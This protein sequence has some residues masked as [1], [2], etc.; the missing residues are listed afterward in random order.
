LQNSC[1]KVGIEP[2]LIAGALCNLYREC[3]GGLHG[4]SFSLLALLSRPQQLPT[5][6][7]DHDECMSKSDEPLMLKHSVKPLVGEQL[8]MCNSVM[9]VLRDRS[10]LQVLDRAH[11]DFHFLLGLAGKPELLAVCIRD[12]RS[13]DCKTGKV[14][15][16][17]A[18]VL[19]VYRSEGLLDGRH[20]IRLVPGGSPITQSML[21]RDGDLT[22]PFHPL[23]PAI[24]G[25]GDAK[26]V[27]DALD[28]LLL[29][30]QSCGAESR[31]VNTSFSMKKVEQ[32]DS[33]R[34]WTARHKSIV[35]IQTTRNSVPLIK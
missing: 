23:Y 34:Y 6:L 15:F 9:N 11:P 7:V 3:A 30:R 22:G 16:L 28:D 8:C 27:A 5:A 1:P 14:Q 19:H 10:H 4:S 12:A 26:H 20:F 18:G 35:G 32:W 25:D 21:L 2:D 29:K 24:L 17:V 33:L 13:A 31:G